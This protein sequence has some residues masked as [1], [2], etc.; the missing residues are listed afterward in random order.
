VY[1]EGDVYAR[2]KVHMDEMRQSARI[3]QQCLDGMPG[4]PWI[5]DDRK[6]VLPPRAELHTSM[7]SLI[8]HF[9]LVT[10]GYRV[11]EG[12]VYLPIESARG[13]LGCYLVSDGGPRPWRVHFRA[14]SFVA[15]Q[16]TASCLNDS[17]IADMIAV[18]ASLDPVMGDV[19]R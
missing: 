11:P 12:E 1:P 7:E 14:P 4:G 2:Y 8:H 10:E 17:L 5:S 18:A 16:A 13:E 3:I 19:D 6:V 15:L 9:K